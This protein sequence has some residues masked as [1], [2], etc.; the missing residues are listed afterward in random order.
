MKSTVFIQLEDINYR[1]K[2]H[3]FDIVIVEK[4]GDLDTVEY[5]SQGVTARTSNG[6]DNLH[7][8][9]EEV[10]LFYKKRF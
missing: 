3:V 7:K 2:D 4:T 1:D 8:L 5:F 6:Y 10:M 9:L